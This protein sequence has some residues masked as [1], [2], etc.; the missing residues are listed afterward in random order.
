MTK[1]SYTPFSAKDGY[2]IVILTYYSNQYKVIK[3]N[4]YMNFTL[5]MTTT[6]A[7][8]MR[9]FEHMTTY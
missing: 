5:L 2:I 7:I 6:L 3:D 9:N 8:V 1:K 4:Y